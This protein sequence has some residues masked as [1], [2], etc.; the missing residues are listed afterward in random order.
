LIVIVTDIFEELPI[1]LFQVGHEKLLR[2]EIANVQELVDPVREI[3]L[4]SKPVTGLE[5]IMT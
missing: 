1:A 5:P 2:M 3:G 4:D